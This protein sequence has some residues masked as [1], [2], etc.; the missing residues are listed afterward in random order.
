MDS[1]TTLDSSAQPV[2]P[3]RRSVRAARGLSAALCGIAAGLCLMLATDTARAQGAEATAAEES[4]ELSRR[5]H[6]L[7]MQLMSPYCPGRTLANCPSPN[8]EAV[9]DEIRRYM[10]LGLSDAEVSARVQ[11]D[12][13][14]GV[15]TP[16]S[17]IGWTLPIAALV[18]GAIGVVA[19]ALRV[20]AHGPQPQAAVPRALANELEAE[21]DAALE[22]RD[23]HIGSPHTSRGS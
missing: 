21:L 20:R 10:E 8:A 12:Y 17:P 19:L 13:G 15:P 16:S 18:L 7:S 23:V 22:A 1:L 6:Q 11:R 4:F 14:V 2:R 5:V 3:A 9:R